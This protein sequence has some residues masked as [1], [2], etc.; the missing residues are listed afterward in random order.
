MKELC[1]PRE[2]HRQD[3]V[4]TCSDCADDAVANKHRRELLSLLPAAYMRQLVSSHPAHVQALS[5]LDVSLPILLS[6]SYL[7]LLSHLPLP[8]TTF[9]FVLLYSVLLYIVTP[10]TDA[11]GGPLVLLMHPCL[12]CPCLCR[13]GFR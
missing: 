8:A 12:S 2:P 5:L 7:I 11:L 10:F 9:I 4:F 1:G 3:L 13:V 6:Q